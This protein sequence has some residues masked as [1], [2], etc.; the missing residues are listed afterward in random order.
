MLQWQKVHPGKTSEHFFFNK[1]L[2]THPI[3]SRTHC[4]VHKRDTKTNPPQVCGSES[5]KSVS[6]DTTKIPQKL[7]C[8]QAIFAGSCHTYNNYGFT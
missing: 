2:S 5:H 8:K 6:E 7:S 3:K 4:E 1:T